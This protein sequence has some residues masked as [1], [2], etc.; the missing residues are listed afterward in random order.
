MIYTSSI[1]FNKLM[2]EAT[3]FIRLDFLRLIFIMSYKFKNSSIRF[4]FQVY[5]IKCKKLK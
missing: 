2:N 4:I 5:L 1:S 3:L